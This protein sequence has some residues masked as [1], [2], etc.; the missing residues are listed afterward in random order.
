MK[1]HDK[2][3]RAFT[4]IE[5]LVVITIIAL[6][7]SILFPAMS[8]AKEKARFVLCKSGVKQYGLAGTLYLYDND[9][10]FPASYEWLY[11]GAYS[12]CNWHDESIDFDRNP[13]HA[14]VL[15]PYLDSKDLHVCPSFRYVAK[16]YGSE[17]HG[18]INSIP[19]SK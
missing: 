6:L 3:E 13:N 11:N 15:W 7:L 12:V 1:K 10:N 17:H 2:V 5:L 4:L 16:D 14:G 18:H 8:R 19:I 9:E